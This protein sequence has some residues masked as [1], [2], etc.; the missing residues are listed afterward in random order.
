[1]EIRWIAEKV[2]VAS[3]DPWR[4]RGGAVVVPGGETHQVCSKA[5]Q[6]PRT[7]L[8][9]E[10]PYWGRTLG[11]LELFIHSNTGRTS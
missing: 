1:M 9:R 3:S 8:D 6:L 4:L 10:S 7:K 2:E 11:Q 5:V